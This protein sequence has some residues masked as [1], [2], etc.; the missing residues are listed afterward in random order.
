MNIKKSL[1]DVIVLLSICAVFAVVLAA[2]NSVTAPIIADRLAGAANE[3]YNAVI[4][5]AEGFEDVDL[6]AYTLP[7]TVKEA[8]RETSGKGYAIKLETKGYDSGMILIIGVS[9]DGV[10]TGATCIESKETNGVEKTYGD[11][12]IGKDLDGTNGVDLVAGSTLTSTAY[13]GAVGDAIKAV[14]IFGGATVETR[15]EEEIFQHNLK[16][17]LGLARDAEESFSKLF[18]AEVL[19]GVNKIYTADSGKGYVCMIGEGETAMF[20][21]IDAEGNSVAV[22]DALTNPVTEGTDELFATANAAI[23]LVNA[24]TSEEIDIE[25]YKNSEDR[26]VKRVFRSINSA[27][28]TATGNYIFELKATGYGSDPIILMV[29]VTV[30]GKTIDV[31]TVSNSETPGI[32]GVQF[33][34]GGFID[35]FI[36]K[37]EEEANGVTTVT[38]ATVTTSAVKKT[39]LYVFTAVTTIEGGAQ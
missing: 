35:N 12:F 29:S 14:A 8:K 4:P 28:K 7:A 11:N 30:D 39:V 16:E 20:V 3:A 19:E 21:G 22:M 18:V 24:T 5:G 38:G 27:K 6:T 37:T 1:K 10:V 26:N 23:T 31:C 9:A 2:T 15:T 17:A 32:G 33:E 25:A 13:R 36:G 34:D